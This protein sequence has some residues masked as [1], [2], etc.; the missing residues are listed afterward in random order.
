MQSLTAVI[1][2]PG[3][4]KFIGPAIKDLAARYLIGSGGA[5]FGE[6]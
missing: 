3:L 5:H 4:E 1:N 2:E 6:I